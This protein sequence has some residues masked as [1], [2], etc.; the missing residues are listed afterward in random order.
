MNEIASKGQLRLAY[1]RWALFCATLLLLFGLG[2]GWLANSGYDNQWFAA[3]QKPELMPPGWV[4]GVV[5]PILY[6]LLGCAAAIVITARGA[7]GR[8]LA[9]ILFVV[10]MI[11]NFAWSPLFFG[12][13]EVRAAL[14]VIGAMLALAIVT[15]LLF[16][17]VRAAAVLLLLPY[18]AWLCF[19]AWLNFEIGR[20]NPDAETLVAPG[21]NTQI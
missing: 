16:A 2:S 14:Y 19:A 10:G 11:L 18:I 3:L 20:L 1:F 12:M 8:V 6:I 13:H 4:F 15:A 5:W 9:L 17:R 7:P 21:I